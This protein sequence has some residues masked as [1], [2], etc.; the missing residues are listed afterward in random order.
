MTGAAAAVEPAEDPSTIDRPRL[1]LSAR[2][3]PPT[4]P[5]FL[6]PWSAAS[7]LAVT[8]TS[9]TLSTAGAGACA[10]GGDDVAT[11][12]AAAAAGSDGP[13]A[14]SRVAF[15]TSASPQRDFL[16]APAAATIRFLCWNKD[17]E[18]LD[19]TGAGALSTTGGAL[20]PLTAVDTPAAPATFETSASPHLDFP[21]LAAAAT[22]AFLPSYSDVSAD[23]A[24]A[25]TDDVEPVKSFN[26]SSYLASTLASAA[27]T[28]FI[29][30]SCASTMYFAMNC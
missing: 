21:A 6:R 4:P 9:T 27:I 8:S 12:A 22:F 10:G 14:A 29:F 24:G 13:F 5:S 17:V 25:G 19:R 28:A 30:C 18:P 7:I 26:F 23:E 3:G 11:V 15:L 16:A 2:D 1:I 20:A